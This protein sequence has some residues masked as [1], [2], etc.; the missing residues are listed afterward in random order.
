[1]FIKQEV[2]NSISAIKKECDD[3]VFNNELFNTNLDST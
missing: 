2:I 1:M 3:L